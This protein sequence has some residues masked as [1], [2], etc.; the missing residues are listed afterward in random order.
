M[1]WSAYDLHI[2]AQEEIGETPPPLPPTATVTPPASFKEVPLEIDTEPLVRPPQL[3]HKGQPVEYWSKTDQTWMSAEV[4]DVTD[5]YYDDTLNLYAFGF[6]VF[7]GLQTVRGVGIMDLRVP[8]AEGESVSV[9]S[10]KHGSW[11]PARIHGSRHTFEP[12]RGYDIKLEDVVE[13]FSWDGEE[14]LT[15]FKSELQKDLA[16]Y[17]GTPVEELL[18]L[19]EGQDDDE[20][21]LKN[22]GANRLRRHY[23]MGESVLLYQG[24]NE[25]FVEAEVV[26]EEADNRPGMENFLV[27]IGSHHGN[28][29]DKSAPRKARRY[30]WRDQRHATVVVRRIS[31]GR[32][33]PQEVTVPEYA[34]RR[35]DASGSEDGPP[36]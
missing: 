31:S 23:N 32:T 5:S 20:P 22:M 14:V 33:P 26:K 34:L 10:Q 18:G 36:W 29:N 15:H 11:C 25:G 27:T 7:V 1:A 28:S 17:K 4:V 9:F 30:N 3:F 21:L 19:A 35:L 13:A 24:A 8:F 12:G 2:G 6:D 16:G